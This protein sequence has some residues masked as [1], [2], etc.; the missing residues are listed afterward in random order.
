MSHYVSSLWNVLASLCN[1]YFVVFLYINS[2]YVCIYRYCLP[3]HS[4]TIV[5]LFDH[6][7]LVNELM[8]A[9]ACD[10]CLKT[11]TLTLISHFFTH[12]MK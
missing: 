8:K 7:Q 10:D 6:T 4:Y 2:M 1:S 11:E 12:C 5:G 9:S 3:I